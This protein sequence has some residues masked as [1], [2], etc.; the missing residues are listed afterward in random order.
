MNH[1]ML[2]HA[3]TWCIVLHRTMQQIFLLNPSKLSIQYC[4]TNFNKGCKHAN[5]TKSNTP[6]HVLVRKSKMVKKHRFLSGLHR[7]S[8]L[9]WA[10]PFIVS[11][12]GPCHSISSISYVQDRFMRAVCKIQ[13]EYGT[14]YNMLSKRKVHGP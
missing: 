12:C 14:W 7:H 3:F 2:P 11:V 13:Y 8:S 1:R 10:C 9:S 5:P 6:S 4:G